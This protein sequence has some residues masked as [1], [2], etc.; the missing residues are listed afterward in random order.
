M[1]T[2]VTSDNP[3]PV[4]VV[5]VGSFGRHHA[6]VY[7]S[8]PTARLVAVVDSDRSRAERVAAKFGCAAL[9]DLR[10]LPPQV[11][12]ASLAVPTQHHVPAGL[13]LL[14][15]GLDLLVEK[16]LAAHAEGAIELVQTAERAG[17][18]LQVGHLERFNPAVEGAA[19][20]ATVPLFFEIHRLSPFSPR[21]LDID[22]VLDLMIH[23]LDIVLSLAGSEVRK[24]D[25]SGL[26]VISDRA[27]IANARLQFESGCV[28]NLT[29]S[30]VSTERVRKLR[31]FQPGEYVSVD[32]MAQSGVSIAVDR[33]AGLR[34]EQLS[35][36]K[37]EPLR[38]QLGAFVRCVRE[39]DK[40]RVSGRD[41]LAAL[42]LAIRIRG[43]I[44]EHSAV[45]SR[46]LSALT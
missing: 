22:V 38:R 2:G 1:R 19:A 41:G 35:V 21:S 26:S 9:D 11:R 8:M 46:T 4:A 31:F 12:A 7:A 42:E 37:G 45:V 13:A 23:D 27:D 3:V 28:A 10:S 15:R 30:R 6:R 44:E 36:N 33:A 25:A 40:P 32:Y 18:I 34:S 24:V 14:R 39:R 20:K 5:G 16:P 29:A 43:A 17:R